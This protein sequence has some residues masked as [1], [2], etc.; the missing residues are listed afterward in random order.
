LESCIVIEYLLVVVSS[1]GEVR[2]RGE[3]P[4]ILLLVTVAH[5]DSTSIGVF[6]VSWMDPTHA[7]SLS[8]VGDCIAIGKVLA[9]LEQRL[10]LS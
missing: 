6:L 9:Y 5:N 3:V 10:Y 1:V 7:I 8:K 2:S 4:D